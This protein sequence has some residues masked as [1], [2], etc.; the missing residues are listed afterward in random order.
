M[1]S[2]MA[3]KQVFSVDHS[4]N[5]ALLENAQ[6]PGS[7]CYLAPLKWQTADRA[8]VLVKDNSL[9]VE[10]LRA[11][12]QITLSC[13]SFD[14]DEVCLLAHVDILGPLHALPEMSSWLQEQ[15]FSPANLLVLNVKV[16]GLEELGEKAI[17]STFRL[18]T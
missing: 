7:E 2:T 8:L 16:L 12:T 10:Q 18:C 13:R 9:L 14:G 5:H 3:H 4:L 1:L 15:V 17:L 6:A 11:D